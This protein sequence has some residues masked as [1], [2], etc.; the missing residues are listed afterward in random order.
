MSAVAKTS[1]Y[2]YRSS[3]GG[4]TDVNIE[5]SADLSA[6]SRLEDKIRL[7]QD[8]LE[9]E[10]ELRQRIEREKA[11]LSVQVIQLSERLE[12]AE[13]GAES[14]FEIN[15]KRDT[16]LTKLRK[17]LEDVHLES[18]ETAHLL[19]RKH[20][21][22]V[23]DFQEQIDQLTKSRAR[24]EKEKSKFQAEVYELLAQV[25]NVT[26]EKIT[27]SKTC[28]RLEVTISE[29]HIK[30]EELNRTIVDITSHKQRLSQENVELV[31]EVQDL[32][33]NI[34]NVVYLRSQLAS[35]LE[36]SRRRLED[37]ER[38]RSLLE[39]N[40]HQVE[41]DLESVRVQL[42]E[43]SEARLD[44]ERQLVK[45]NGEVSHW[46]SKYEAEAAARAEEI[47]EIRR[48][49]SIRIQEQEEQIETLIAKIS[50]IEKQKSRLQS[51]VEVLIIDLEKA[52][53][54]ARE[55]QKRTEQL[56]RVN[57]EI[58]SRLEETVQLYEQTQR[59]LRVKITEIQRISHELDKTREQ[60]DALGRENKKLGDD[61]HDAR[62]NLTELNRRLH[63]LEIELRRLENE[64]E[65]LTAA[66][67]EAEAGRKA[68][69]QRA[70]RL[71]SELGQFRHEAE[72]RLQEKEEE[73]E[74]IRPPTAIYEDNYGY[75]I[76]FYQPM[77]DYIS[78]KGQGVAAKPP[79]LPW[80][81]ER[82][83]DKYRFDKPIRTYSEEDV[84]R[85]SHEIADQAKRDLN[86]FNVTKRSPFSVIATADAA[87]VVKHVG[88]ES[89]TSKT[90]KKKEE[91]DKYKIERQKKRMNEIE[92]ELQLY[93]KEVNVGAELRGKAKM[94]R[95][96]SAKAIAQTLLQESRQNVSESK[97]TRIEYRGKRSVIDKNLSQITQNVLSKAVVQSKI[98]GA[99][100]NEISEKMTETI[101]RAIRE[102]SPTTCVVRIREVPAIE[103]KVD[104]S[105]LQPLNELKQT[106]KQ[107]DQLNTC[108]LIDSSKQT[109]IEIEQ[110]NARVV[111]AETK[112]KSE[113]TRIKKKL[114]IQIT[115]LELSLDVANKTNIDLQKVVK[116]QSLQL[117]E[118]QTHYDE[119]QRQLQVT[120]DQY[121]VAQRRIQSL[122]GEVE[123]I[124][125]NYEQ[126]L[127]AKRT[128]EQS[129]EEAVTRINELT[130]INV[131][132]SSSKAKIEQELAAVAADYDEITKELRIADERYQRVQTELKHT[133]EH[134]HEEQERIVKIE[135][136]KKSLEIEVKNI[137]VRLE[138]VEANAIV[139][140]KR[141][142]SKLEARIKD[143]ELEM[144][145]EKRR[146]AETIKILRKKERQ[147]KEVMIQ[148]EEDQKNIAL[149]QD[150]LEKTTQKVNIY[151]RQLTEQEGMSQQNVTRV[152]RF[153]RELEAAEDR[154]DCA[155][156]NLSLIRAK[157]RTFVTTST[158]PGSQVYL[159]Q[160]SRAISSER[161]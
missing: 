154:A 151:K 134:L 101:H 65:E 137:S 4:T 102:T 98:S 44:L 140:G 157:H 62:A 32:K 40:L 26:K 60:K 77:I 127:R 150:S 68:E 16:E 10:R 131:N 83:L 99:A 64:R 122:T 29:L 117:T 42:E 8:D 51:E 161:M 146:H 155:E 36:D 37:E 156:S 33:V 158:V 104:E 135:A 125:G 80:N 81:N 15:R 46:K 145:E 25:E 152:R 7:L 111:E 9:S 96:K 74:A 69:E 107:F 105:Y 43:E 63:E 143:M 34:E 21:E 41:I 72:R 85:L 57:I 106:I 94:Y 139:G 30:I 109:S 128:A 6:L 147:L 54:T 53:G 132:L 93:E 86:T 18:E 24:A 88:T 113:V 5:Y 12:E 39:A 159:V 160:E 38:R 2:T 123:E 148:C 84:T 78:A 120:L 27:I 45:A 141:I 28:E 3:G 87:N 13:G 110:L 70:M 52:N 19:K 82:G 92:K 114:Q 49:Y 31:K 11:D 136:V 55:L 66:Y 95:G 71:A 97:P 67:K 61:L 115:E 47:E 133:V 20:Q 56:E 17:L 91:R 89:V 116:K 59:D 112:L 129:Y 14:Q 108:L 58:K 48:K 90:R 75:G 35:Q 142:I 130:V 76:N 50:S 121:G 153:Q 79:H 144:D 23:V 149:L 103:C 119:V 124:R 22:I 100:A 126:A 1:K 73:I 138:E 118:I